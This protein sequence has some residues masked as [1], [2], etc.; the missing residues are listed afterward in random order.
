MADPRLRRTAST[1]NLKAARG[2]AFVCKA[3]CSFRDALD[4]EN[5]DLAP[6]C[7]TSEVTPGTRRPSVRRDSDYTK[8]TDRADLECRWRRVEAARGV[9]SPKTWDAAIRV[10]ILG[11]YLQPRLPRRGPGHSNPAGAVRDGDA[12]RRST[13]GD[14]GGSERLSRIFRMMQTSKVDPPDDHAR[15]QFRRDRRAFR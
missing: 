14:R 5:S 2:T 1:C 3:T 12:A 7:G 8:V 9:V 15:V 13:A 10:T 6:F 11:A 4:E